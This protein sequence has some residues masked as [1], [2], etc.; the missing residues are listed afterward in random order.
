MLEV[1]VLW[2]NMETL[3]L[4]SIAM[5]SEFL[6]EN[7]KGDPIERQQFVLKLQEVSRSTLS[8]VCGI[9]AARPH[10]L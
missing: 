10:Q 8:V 2:E 9:Q 1:Q 3:V 6:S 4:L 5:T 7:W